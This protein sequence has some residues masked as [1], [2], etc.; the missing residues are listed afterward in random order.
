MHEVGEII[1]KRRIDLG[2]SLRDVAVL[3]SISHSQ[4]SKIERGD[5]RPASNTL[6]AILSALHFTND[7]IEKIYSTF[8]S[9][10]I[11]EFKHL[12]PGSFPM[13]KESTSDYR[14]EVS[15]KRNIV[16]WLVQNEEGLSYKEIEL[17][18]DEMCDFFTARKRSI[19]KKR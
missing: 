11:S 13:I 7:E 4:L 2:L 9:D 3:A 12:Y 5:S 18:A 14:I 15:M 1:R 16:N 19:L 8:V 10:D 6:M 17:I